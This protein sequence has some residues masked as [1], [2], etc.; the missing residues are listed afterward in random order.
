M[1]VTV[2]FMPELIIGCSLSYYYHEK[3]DGIGL[4]NSFKSQAYH[5]IGIGFFNMYI[6][7]RFEKKDKED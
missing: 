7:I 5:R 4:P 2:D 1:K 6:Q 3:I